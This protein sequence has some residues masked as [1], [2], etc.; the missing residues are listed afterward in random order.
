[1]QNHP[2]IIRKGLEKAS[3]A[4]A[5]EG[6]KTIEDPFQDIFHCKNWDITIESEPETQL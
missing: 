1:M 4:W 6:A 5:L 3:I 2:E